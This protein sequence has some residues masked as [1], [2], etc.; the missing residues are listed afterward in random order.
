MRLRIVVADQSAA[1]ILREEMPAAV[2][3]IVTAEVG[4][5]LVHEPPD[6]LPGHLPPG[7]F[8]EHPDTV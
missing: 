7:I 8:A 6:R 3:A 1:D 5:D 2:H 4:K